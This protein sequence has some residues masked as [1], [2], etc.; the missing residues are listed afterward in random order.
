MMPSSR[1]GET[2][3]KSKRPPPCSSNSAEP[4]RIA[5]D[6]SRGVSVPLQGTHEEIAARLGRYSDLG[7]KHLQIV[8]DPINVAS[9]E[10]MAEILTGVK[11]L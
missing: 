4:G 2:R 7:I 10:E 11:S 9:I 8:L 5:G 1:P 6:P 3:P